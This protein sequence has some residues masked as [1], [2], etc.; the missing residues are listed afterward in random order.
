MVAAGLNGTDGGD[1][2]TG[3]QTQP[4]AFNDAETQTGAYL[5]ARENCANHGDRGIAQ[6][7]P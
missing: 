1:S 5:E 7:L 6:H 4:E 3:N 2:V